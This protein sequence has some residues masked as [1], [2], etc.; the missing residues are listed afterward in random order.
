MGPFIKWVKAMADENP[1]V[2]QIR[3]A[4]LHSAKRCPKGEG[5]T[6]PRVNPFPSAT[7]LSI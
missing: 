3:R 1:K 6:R 7:H 2:R 4:N 5:R